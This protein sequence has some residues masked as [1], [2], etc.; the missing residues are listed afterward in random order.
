MFAADTDG[1]LRLTHSRT[2]AFL[3]Q[4]LGERFI[5]A[6]FRIIHPQMSV[7][8]YSEIMETWN[9]MWEFPVR[10]RKLKNQEILFMVLAL[11]ARVVNLKDKEPEARVE[12]WAEH[13]SSRAAEGPIFLQE[14]SVKGMHL[15]L[16]KVSHLTTA[17]SLSADRLG[18]VLLAINE[19]KRRISLSWP[20]DK[21]C[22]GTGLASFP[23]D[24]RARA[25]HAPTATDLLDRLC[26]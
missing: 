14:P 24:G 10:G 4:A 16:L 11:G 15:M 9:Q 19:T 2:E 5:E 17:K 12:G 1:D 13:F 26:L 20:R 6:Y 8:V 22:Y 21:D 7:L 23:S 25:T 18:Y 3:P